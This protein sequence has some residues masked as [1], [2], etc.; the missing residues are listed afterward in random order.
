MQP[1]DSFVY[2]FLFLIPFAFGQEWDATN[3]PNPT[4]GGFRECKMKTTSSICDPDE[5]LTEAERYRLN[6][7]LNQLE[8]TVLF[9][10]F[11]D[12]IKC[13]LISARTRQDHAPTFCEKKGVTGAMAVAKHFRGGSE[14]VS[15]SDMLKGI[16]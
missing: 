6:H 15:L 8:G 5:V 11:N 12:S 16:L 13:G 10:K 14:A 2:I 3:F 9:L 1:P 4:A 7:E